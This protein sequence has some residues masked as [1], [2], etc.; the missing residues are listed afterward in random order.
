MSARRH[1]HHHKKPAADISVVNARHERRKVLLAKAAK[2]SGLPESDL[3]IE[4]LSWALLGLDAE[5]Q[6]LLRGEAGSISL[7][8]DVCDRLQ[9]LCPKPDVLRVHFIDGSDTCIKCRAPLPP[10]GEREPIK[11]PAQPVHASNR[12]TPTLPADD[13]PNAP[14]TAPAPARP[15]A[16]APSNVTPLRSHD[17][18]FAPLAREEPWRASIG[19]EFRRFDVPENF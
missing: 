9:G 12:D 1:R 16:P 4:T 2:S 18:V 11:P 19:S 10:A 3:R 8:Q 6:R 14:A 17:H 7:W 15:Q 5:K 13:D